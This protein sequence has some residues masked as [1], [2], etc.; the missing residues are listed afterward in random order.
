MCLFCRATTVP[1][2]SGVPLNSGESLF[3][4]NF[5][6]NFPNSPEFPELSPQINENHANTP[7]FPLKILYLPLK[8]LK[9][10]H[11]EINASP[12][13]SQKTIFT[14]NLVQISLWWWLCS[15]VL[16]GPNSYQKNQKFDTETEKSYFGI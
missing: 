2:I 7:K 14:R 9:I 12:I 3:S 10:V 15:S 16:F 5:P 6:P 4:P 1:R 11:F 13:F 8:L